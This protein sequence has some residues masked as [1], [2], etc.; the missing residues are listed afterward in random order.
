MDL[1]GSSWL[2]GVGSRV[3]AMPPDP[4]CPAPVA[5]DVAGS[6]AAARAL[7]VGAGGLYAAGAEGLD[8]AGADTP[9]REL[10]EDFHDGFARGCH[11]PLEEAGAEGL[12]T[13]AG[14]DGVEAAGAAGAGALP[15]LDAMYSS[16]GESSILKTAPRWFTVLRTPVKGRSYSEFGTVS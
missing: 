3:S 14:A 5:V 7:G 2:T 12:E 4:T 13:R 15:P 9:P 8:T 6:G 1:R 16:Y 10:G 11:L